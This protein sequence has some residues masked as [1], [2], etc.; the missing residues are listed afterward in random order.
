LARIEARPP[1]KYEMKELSPSQFETEVLSATS[2]VLV[3]FYAPWCG[4]CRMLAPMLESLGAEYAGRVSLVKLN[5]DE[6]PDL[7]SRYQISG[8]PTLMLFRHGQV[9][10]SL[11]GV[12]SIRALRGRL[13]AVAGAAHPATAAA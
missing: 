10:D 3:D 13:D 9:V 7:A 6:A 2:P 11:V 12:P 4:P 5:V 8:V 1:P